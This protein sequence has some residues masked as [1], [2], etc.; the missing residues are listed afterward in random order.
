MSMHNESINQE[1]LPIN[2][3]VSLV[4]GVLICQSITI[5]PESLFNDDTLKGKDNQDTCD[6]Q[7][8]HIGIENNSCN[9][10]VQYHVINHFFRCN[11][12]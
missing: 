10:W 1:L 12:M 7:T 8:Q 4:Y 5:E 11:I 6:K 3:E 9:Q 2:N